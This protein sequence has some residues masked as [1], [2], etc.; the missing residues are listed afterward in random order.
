LGLKS[1][2]WRLCRQAYELSGM[3][4]GLEFFSPDDYNRFSSQILQ[5]M[6]DWCGRQIKK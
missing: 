4:N 2:V 1:S 3:A 5:K 6:L